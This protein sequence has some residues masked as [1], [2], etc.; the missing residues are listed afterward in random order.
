MARYALRPVGV[1]DNDLGRLIVPAMPE[2][3]VYSA[4]L[5]EGNAPDPLPAPA[6]EGIGRRRARRKAEA[7]ALAIASRDVTVQTG[8]GRFRLSDDDRA[9]LV[10][11]ASYANA[12]NPLPDGFGFPDVDDVFVPLSLVQLRNIVERFVAREFRARVRFWSLQAEIDAATD[13]DSVPIGGGWIDD[14][15]DLIA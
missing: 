14:D 8:A 7:R 11:A 1:W 5:A 4:W 9:F 2:W 15:P 13:P 10:S 12:A 6:P 3:V